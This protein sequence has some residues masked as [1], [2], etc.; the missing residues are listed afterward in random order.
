M[1][2]FVA[3]TAGR[4]AQAAVDVS[5]IADVNSKLMESMTPS[6]EVVDVDNEAVSKERRE[7]SRN[8]R[9]GM[10]SNIFSIF[11]KAKQDFGGTRRTLLGE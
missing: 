11:S 8:Y 5:G 7:V 10:T 2:G 6:K 4:A 9:R 1:S 3:G